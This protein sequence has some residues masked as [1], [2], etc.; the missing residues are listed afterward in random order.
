[1]IGLARHR[2]QRPAGSVGFYGIVPLFESA[3]ALMAIGGEKR[4][5]RNAI[6]YSCSSMVVDEANAAQSWATKHRER[7]EVIRAE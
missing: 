5:V 2:E 6:L 1:V 7:C 3:K 4:I